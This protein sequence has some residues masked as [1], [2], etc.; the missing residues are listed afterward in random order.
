VSA[1]Y[2]GSIIIGGT[3]TG[4][5]TATSCNLKIA[6]SS[7]TARVSDTLFELASNPFQMNT[8]SGGGT[9]ALQT[10]VTAPEPRRLLVQSTGYGP[11]GAQKRLEMLVS[12]YKYDIQPPAPVVIR[13]SDDG[14]T[15][16]FNLGSSNAKKYSGKDNSKV[17]PKFPT[18]AISL[19]DW[20]AANDGIVKGATVDDPKLSILDIDAIP[21]PWPSTLTPVPSNTPTPPTPA[22]PFSAQTPSFLQT[23]NNARA[24]LNDIEATAR[25]R[26]RYFSTLTGYAG[27]L[28]S[29]DLTF[30]DGNCTLSGGA[31]LLI[32]TGNLEM[33]G[34][35]DFKGVILVLG[36]GRVTRSGTGNGRVLG[37]WMIASFS[38]TGT[39]GFTAP[40][41]NVSGG[42]NGSFLYDTASVDAANKTA[43]GSVLGIAER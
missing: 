31:G 37:S 40:S 19:H 7:K 11:R 5:V 32:V 20:Y 22:Y 43:G 42:G 2:E 14:T 12:R 38:R 15:M 16:T 9:F 21:S 29:P 24:F 17:Q 4:K 3:I 23:A 1:P 35:D 33:T 30:V 25:A 6:F 13:G 34:N 36:S 39:G 26:G 27:S 41:F 8:A 18:I 10:T 28:T